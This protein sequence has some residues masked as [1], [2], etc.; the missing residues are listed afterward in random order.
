M[1][2]PILTVTDLSVGFETEAGHVQAVQNLSYQVRPGEALAIVGESGSGKSVSS[3]AVM[4]LL[5]GSAQ[6]TGDIELMGK[7]IFTMNDRELSQLRG[8]TISMVFQ[9]P[10]SALTPVFTVGDQISEVVRIHHPDVSKQKAADRAVE[11]LEAVGIPE[12]RRRAQQYPHEFSGGMRQRV[13]IAMAIANEPELIIADE[14]TTALDVTIQAQVMELL[15]SAQEMLGAATILITHDMGVVAGFAD[16]VLV[17]KDAQMVETGGVEQIFYE[18]REQY[19]RN[20]L[21]AVPRIDQGAEGGSVAGAAMRKVAE[22]AASEDSR[23]REAR[24]AVLEVEDL[25]RIYPITKGAVVRRKVGEQRAV[26]GISFDIR[27][28]ECMALVGESGCGKTTTL[29][30]IMQLRTP[31]QGEIR[32]DGRPT[33]SL[34][35]KERA[36]L[37]SEVTLVFQD[38]MASLDPRMPIGDILKEPMRVQG[39]SAKKMN[40]RVDWLLKTVELKPEHASRYPTEFS[41][42]QR[43]RVGV[44]RALACDPKLIILDEPTSALDVTVQAGVLAL[45]ADLKTRLGV[46]YLFV[47]HDL[48]VVRHIS[49]RISVMRKGQI[50]ESGPTERVFDDPQHEYTKELL[51]AVP[52]PDPRIARTR[53]RN[54]IDEQAFQGQGHGGVGTG[55][56]STS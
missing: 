37:R 2:D 26:D 6:I 16:R 12:P 28:G 27:E 40:E 43:Q 8:D 51:A 41:G 29:M 47:S 45:L 11:L 9:D 54:V 55:S 53:G 39:Y 24:P 32:I 52:I 13:M 4:G 31:Q 20:L 48:S 56:L 34:S 15:K 42:G 50:V 22:V 21:S 10:L 38:P 36:K 17:M 25:H 1:S 35:R 30:E 23:P 44:A 46:S 33:G 49:D 7:K 3:L 14:P 18:P 5:P 19:T